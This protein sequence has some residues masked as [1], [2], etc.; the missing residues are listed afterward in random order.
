MTSCV[1]SSQLD[2]SKTFKQRRCWGQYKFWRKLSHLGS[3]H[4]I[5]SEWSYYCSCSISYH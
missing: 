2:Y 1:S 3:S 5:W 4:C